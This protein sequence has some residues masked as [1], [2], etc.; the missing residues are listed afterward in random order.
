MQRR[1]R[2][3]RPTR[4]ST[5]CRATAS[6]RRRLIAGPPR[7]RSIVRSASAHHRRAR[8]RRPAPAASIAPTPWPH[9]MNSRLTSTSVPSAPPR[10]LTPAFVRGDR[11]L[12]ERLQLLGVLLVVVRPLVAHDAAGLAGVRPADDGAVLGRGEQ[13]LLVAVHRAGLGR[14][15]E[16]G[17]DPHAV[18]T[19]RQRGG[20]AAA[21][22]QTAGGDDRHLGRRL[23]RRPAARAPSWPPCRCGR[24]PRCPGRRRSR[25]RWR[26]R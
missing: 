1:Q 9:G 25:R 10:W 11:L 4:A 6:R 14:G 18:G 23:R 26:P 22:E 5:C 7:S 2:C 24:R 8:C 17:A 19:E 12:R 3:R 21:V 16:A 13:R 15:D 20:Q